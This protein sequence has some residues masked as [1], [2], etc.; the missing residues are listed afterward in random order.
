MFK[1]SKHGFSGTDTLIGQG[2]EIEGK[3]KCSTNLRIEGKVKGDIECSQDITV[4][5]KSECHSDI[6][7]KNIVVAGKVHGNLTIKEQLTIMPT[8]VINGNFSSQSLVIHDG[9]IFN[10]TSSMTVP[11]KAQSKKDQEAKK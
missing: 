5:E 8:G 9:G 11:E 1:A 4:G 7:A 10:G 2:T 3:V 6:I